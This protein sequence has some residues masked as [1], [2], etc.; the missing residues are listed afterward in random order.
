MKNTFRILGIAAF[1]ALIGFTMAACGDGGGGGGGNPVVPSG[2]NATSLSISP[3][4]ETIKLGETLKPTVTIR[5]SDAPIINWRS[6]DTDVAT[7]GSD[8]TISSKSIGKVIVTVTAKGGKT[9][10][11]TIYVEPDLKTVAN[12][13][14]NFEKCVYGNGRFVAGGMYGKI[15]WSENGIDWTEVDSKFTSKSTDVI[16]DIAY[17]NG[18]FVAV[19]GETSSDSWTSAYKLVYSNTRGTSWTIGTTGIS[20]EGSFGSV[21]FGNNIFLAGGSKGLII[22]S[23]DGK[24]WKTVATNIFGGTY[25]V[26]NLAYGNNTFV[27]TSRS[28]I[29]YST[30]N[31]ANWTIIDDEKRPFDYEFINRIV[32]GKGKFVAISNSFSAHVAY[33]VD[34]KNWTALTSP[35]FAS[36]PKCITYGDGIFIGGGTWRFEYSRDGISWSSRRETEG[37]YSW[38]V[39]GNGMFVGNYEHNLIYA[40]VV[41][42]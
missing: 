4:Y 12:F 25:L 26:E 7:V 42:R 24:T 16:Y 34:G 8:G 27:A 38:V 31:G 21:T 5:P 30:N 20:G 33:S 29:A 3:R 1:V 28:K 19:G 37:H 15:A 41:L 9:D 11:C 6:N 13:N 2:P 23:Q 35:F 39:I 14:L 10:T 32:F 22:S 18:T 17:G 40:P 36:N